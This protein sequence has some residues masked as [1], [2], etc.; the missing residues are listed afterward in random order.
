[1]AYRVR[2]FDGVSKKDV[3]R[4]EARPTEG[5]VEQCIQFARRNPGHFALAQSSREDAGGIFSE[6]YFSSLLPS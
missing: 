1:M 2:L 5:A 4:N 3:T 6:A